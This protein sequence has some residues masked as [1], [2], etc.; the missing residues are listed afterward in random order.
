MLDSIYDGVQRPLDV[1][2]GK[3]GS[4]YL[5]RG[6]DAPGIDLEKKWEFEPTVEVGDEVGRGDVV[7]VVERRS[8]S[9]TR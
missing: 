4:P 3:M 1:L 6:V 2:E 9:T 7:G 8:P 5:D